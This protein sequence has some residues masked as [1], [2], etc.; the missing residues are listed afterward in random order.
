M[1]LGG[2]PVEVLGKMYYRTAGGDLVDLPSDMTA[3]QVIQLEAFDRTPTPA[4]SFM[5]HAHPPMQAQQQESERRFAPSVYGSMMTAGGL[6]SSRL[7]VVV[8]ARARTPR[9]AGHS[10]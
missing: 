3:A 10:R 9:P 1:F 4:P 2:K 6:L 8:R 7:P 5:S